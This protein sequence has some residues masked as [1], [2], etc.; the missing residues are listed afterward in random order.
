MS[1]E[2]KSSIENEKITRPTRVDI[3]VKNALYNISKIQEFVGE[4]ITIMPVIKASG[5]GT[6]INTRLDF[7]NN[8]EIVAV[9]IVDEGILLRKLGYKKDIFILN[10]P[11]TEE[12]E[13]IIDN[14][15]IVG[16]SSDH[17]VDDLGKFEKTVKVHIEIGTGMGRTGVHPKRTEEYIDKIKKYP[18]I[19]IDG[20]YT[21]LSSADIDPE[22]TKKQLKSFDIAVE[23]AKSKVKSVVT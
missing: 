6:C 9:A 7:L 8:F 20:I 22:Y 13:K 5:Y 15:L 14:N 11:D 10:Q 12:I 16:I 21:H 18:N 4:N 3:S 1:N 2:L 17:F 23:I 19:I